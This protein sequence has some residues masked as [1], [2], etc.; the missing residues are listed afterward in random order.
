MNHIDK[1]TRDRLAKKVLGDELLTLLKI[2]MFLQFCSRQPKDRI[3]TL[4]TSKIVLILNFHMN[5]VAETLSSLRQARM[6][7]AALLS[8]VSYATDRLVT[9]KQHYT[10]ERLAKQSFLLKYVTESMHHSDVRIVLDDGARRAREQLNYMG[11]PANGV[12]LVND[13]NDAMMPDNDGLFSSEERANERIRRTEAHQRVES[14]C[15]AIATVGDELT[16]MGIPSGSTTGPV[17]AIELKLSDSAID[18]ETLY[19]LMTILRDKPQG[20]PPLPIP[21][22]SSSHIA[23]HDLLATLGG[24][25]TANAA[26][27]TSSNIASLARSPLY[28]NPCHY[29]PLPLPSLPL[30]SHYHSSHCL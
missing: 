26:T 28:L 19:N 13:G 11:K 4:L 15:H 17:G 7:T 16:K 25:G 21:S 22:S 3:P 20:L 29:P 6:E 9:T 10:R 18:D 1:E 27:T 23:S 5:I 2:P 8:R 12:N 30:P 24:G 14:L